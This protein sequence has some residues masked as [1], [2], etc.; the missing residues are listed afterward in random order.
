MWMRADAAPCVW[1]RSHARFSSSDHSE[2]PQWFAEQVEAFLTDVHG[3]IAP[4][5]RA[6]PEPGAFQF[7]P[8][9]GAGSGT[10]AVLRRRERP[11]RAPRTPAGGRR[12]GSA[13]STNRSTRADPARRNGRAQ[14]EAASLRSLPPGARDG[15]RPGRDT[16]AAHPDGAGRPRQR[17][18]AR[19]T[20]AAGFGATTTGTAGPREW[21]APTA[22]AAT[23][24]P[25]QPHHRPGT[26]RGGH[27]AMSTVHSATVCRLGV[28]KDR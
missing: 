23:R 16:S 14:D 24:S 3:P 28:M 1:A 15:F 11:R 7:S 26:P 4:E 22:Q 8:A 2:A 25:P 10:R 27:L 20:G 5:V 17:S 21:R 9:V 13:G 6:G 18:A 19:R 12:R